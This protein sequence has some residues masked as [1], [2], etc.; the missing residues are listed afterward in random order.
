MQVRKATLSALLLLCSIPLFIMSAA[1]Q[2]NQ[3]DMTGPDPGAGLSAGA[4]ISGT[5]LDYTNQPAVNVRMEL[6]DLTRGTVVAMS[7][8]NNAG[9]YQFANI[10]PGNYEVVAI[11]GIRESREKVYVFGGTVALNL[12]F[13]APPAGADVDGNHTV[14]VSDYKVPGKARDAVRKA[15]M[16]LHDGD[17]RRMAHYVEKALALDPNYGHALMLRGLLELQDQHFEEARQDLEKSL[18]L[19]SGK[20][21]TYFLLAAVYNQT[22][23]YDDALLTTNAG[24]RLDPNAWQGYFENSKALLGKHQFLDALREVTRALERAPNLPMLHLIKGDAYAGLRDY[25]NA[26]TEMQSYISAVPKGELAEKVRGSIAR[27]KTFAAR[28]PVAPAV[29]NLMPPNP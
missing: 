14:D 18:Q 13:D 12:R 21:P 26:I 11:S 15:E 7:V 20:A 3:F 24:L 1:A 29:G 27:M 25:A 4:S 5:V 9:V 19:D 23:R 6:H 8:T 10:R 17:L 28:E 16:A 2:M 22:K